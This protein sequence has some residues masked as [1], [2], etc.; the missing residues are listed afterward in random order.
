[1]RDILIS[2]DLTVVNY[3]LRLGK[4]CYNLVTRLLCTC[5]LYQ[6]NCRILAKSRADRTIYEAILGA[7]IRLAPRVSVVSAASTTR[8]TSGAIVESGFGVSGGAAPKG[9]PAGTV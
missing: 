5:G 7:I 4:D 1:M 3:R 9:F 6:R 8:A 2:L